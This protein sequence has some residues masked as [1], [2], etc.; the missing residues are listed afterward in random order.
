ML[1]SIDT[2]EGAEEQTGMTGTQG[3]GT[4]RAVW[5]QARHG[6]GECARQLHRGELAK[7]K[8]RGKG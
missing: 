6:E 5:G 7:S 8:L 2:S 4:M 1:V 3:M